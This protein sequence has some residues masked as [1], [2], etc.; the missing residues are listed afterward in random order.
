M[1]NSPHTV[2]IHILDNDSLLNIFHHY[3]PFLLGEDDG[4]S[5]RLSGGGHWVRGRWWYKLAH[6]CQLW[7]KIILGSSSYLNISLVCANGTSV[8]DMLA[9]SPPLSLDFDYYCDGYY[10]FTAEDEKGILLALGKR[11]SVRRVRLFLPVANLQ[12]LIGAID[13]EYPILEY[14]LIFPRTEEGHPFVIFPETFHAPHLR[15]LALAGFAPPIGS[16]LLTTAAGLVT[17]F[18]HTPTFFY[19]NTLLQCLSFIP[20]LETLVITFSSPIPNRDVERQL[21]WIPIMTHVTLS[22]LS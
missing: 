2:S 8:L 12:K 13:E 9:H 5:T 15:H 19:P 3:R 6:V 11:D 7:R 21:S 17:L 14:L 20:Q 10:D 1:S 16:R 18:P 4:D 22:N